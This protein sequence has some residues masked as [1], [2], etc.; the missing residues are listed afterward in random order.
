MYQ[1]V[2][3]LAL[4]GQ[5]QGPFLA[6]VSEYQP[7]GEYAAKSS[8]GPR[9]PRAL[10]FTATWCPHCQ[11]GK[12]DFGPRLKAADWQLD[13]TDRAHVQFVDADAHPDLVKKYGVVSLPSVVLLT[14]ENTYSSAVPYINQQSLTSLFPASTKTVS[15]SV[16]ESAPTPYAEV[17]RILTLLPTPQVGFVDFGCGADARW[18]ILAA[19][20]WGCKCTGI[21]I[22][23]SRAATARE[24]VE[25]SGLGHLITIVNA[26]STEMD[27]LADVGVAYLY[28][29]TLEKLKPKIEKLKAF[30][31][32]MHKPAGIATTQNG[33]AWIYI[34]SSPAVAQVQSQGRAAVWGG[35]AY[36][37]PVCNNPGCAMC[38]SIRRQ[39]GY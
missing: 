38:N 7:T 28:N 13:E 9:Y 26:D 23:P 1:L 21:E 17:S 33:N 25:A 16:S 8:L 37:G 31:S 19:E 11:V 5:E 2:I 32:Y 35:Q 4:L 39:L 12:N 18:C 15:T 24:R 34:K 30:A 22:D 14:D 10:Y 3:L 20:K 6:S 27:V 29:E 36:A